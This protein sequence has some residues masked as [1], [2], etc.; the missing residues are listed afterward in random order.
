[1]GF[2]KQTIWTGVP[3]ACRPRGT[4]QPWKVDITAQRRGVESSLRTQRYKLPCGEILLNSP[5]HAEHR[6]R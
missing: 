6:P 3:N 1:M 2:V 4:F 5:G